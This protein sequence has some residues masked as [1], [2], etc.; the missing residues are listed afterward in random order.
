MISLI[1]NHAEQA[2]ERLR[3]QYK[4]KPQLIALIN[5]WNTQIQEL[6]EV[7]FNLSTSRS[8]TTSIGYQLDLLGQLLSKSREG[9]SDADYRI[10]LL[11]KV[12]KNISRGTPEDVIGVFKILTSSSQVQLSDGY[13][14]EVYLLADHALTQDQINNIL[15]EINSVVPAGVRVNALGSFDADDSFAFNGTDIAKGF[16]SI[17]DLSKGGKLATIRRS[18]EKKFAFD[19]SNTSLGGFGSLY[20][21]YSGGTLIAL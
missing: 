18:N 11:A 8:I 15:R 4:N 9:R 6:E 12:A 14:G 16:S 17:Y 20:D 7:L 21:S 3:E 10:V 1:T 19:G 5:S 13:N 2:L